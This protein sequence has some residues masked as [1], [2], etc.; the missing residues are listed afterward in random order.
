MLSEYLKIPPEE[1]IDVRFWERLTAEL[2]GSENALNFSPCE[3]IHELFQRGFILPQTVVSA[4]S[5]YGVVEQKRNHPNDDLIKLAQRANWDGAKANRSG[6]SSV[7]TGPACDTDKCDLSHQYS[8]KIDSWTTSTF[9]CLP[10]WLKKWYCTNLDIVD[11]LAQVIPFGLNDHGPGFG[12]LPDFRGRKKTGL[13]YVNFQDNTSERLNL[14]QYYSQIPWVTFRD[15][16]NI[17]VDQFLAEVADHKFILSPPGNGLDCYRNYEAM[18]LGSFPLLKT[19]TFSVELGKLGLPLGTLDDMILGGSDV[20]SMLET[21]FEKLSAHQFSY[22][23]LTKSYWKE[24]IY[25]ELGL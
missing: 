21:N 11:D 14:K 23:A 1:M 24:R 22:E 8:I 25:R 3:H 13:L 4:Y 10:S 6:Y 12:M 16:A 5:D 15:T 19:S 18:Y 7:V 20:K 9:P 17:P 2:G